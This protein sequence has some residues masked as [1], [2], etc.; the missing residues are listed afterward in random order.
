MLI[1]LVLASVTPL[2]STESIFEV[3]IVL[4]LIFWFKLA[5]MF[6]PKNHQHR[7]KNASKPH[8]GR[9]RS[10][11]RIWHRFFMDLGSILDANL[12]PCWLLFP[13]NWG[14]LWRAP[15]F[16]VGSM[17]FFVF[18]PYWPSVGAFWAR[19]LEVEARILDVCWRALSIHFS[20]FWTSL[21]QQP[22]PYAEALSSLESGAGWAGG[23]TRSAKKLN[24]HTYL[25]LITAPIRHVRLCV[26][27]SDHLRYDFI[28]ILIKNT[29]K[30]R[31]YRH[32][33]SKIPPKFDFIGFFCQK[34]P[35]MRFFRNF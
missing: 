26:S 19:F 27:I 11:D 14:P 31:F 34:H 25:P 16:F 32:F 13:S 1:F 18:W 12:A 35:K 15:L 5:F 17:F 29:S 33:W 24:A 3:D 28:S 21:F 2:D 8:L 22:E 4:L 7:F 23:V 10:L 20:S 6:P 30:I 9:H